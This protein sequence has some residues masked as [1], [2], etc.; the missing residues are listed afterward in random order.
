MDSPV[1]GYARSVGRRGTHRQGGRNWVAASGG[2][3]SAGRT[4]V[5]IGPQSVKTS[6]VACFADGTVAVDMDPLS[7]LST[8]GVVAAIA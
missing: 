6:L 2:E 4:S 3:S 5:R 1:N 8:P 7:L